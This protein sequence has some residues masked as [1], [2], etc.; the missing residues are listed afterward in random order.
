M[1]PKILTLLR[2]HRKYKWRVMRA[3]WTS[4]V[5]TVVQAGVESF[6][7]IKLV[8]LQRE[9]G[10]ATRRHGCIPARNILCQ[11]HF[12]NFLGLGDGG[13]FLGWDRIVSGRLSL[14]MLVCLV[15]VGY[16]IRDLEEEKIACMMSL[17][18]SGGMLSSKGLR[19]SW[20]CQKV[21]IMHMSVVCMHM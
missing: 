8:P 11:Y 17:L 10:A 5:I 18:V 3:F 6:V 14:M 2:R 13:G 19:L 1:L 16:G 9:L 4:S 7:G 12:L 21:V 20:G 15:A